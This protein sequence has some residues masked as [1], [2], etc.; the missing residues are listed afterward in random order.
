MGSIARLTAGRWKILLPALL[1]AAL[2]AVGYWQFDS[3][4]H[5]P[6]A[7]LSFTGDL[8]GTMTQLRDSDGHHSG[9]WVGDVERT[10]QWDGQFV[11]TVN[12]QRM[13]FNIALM[14]YHG[15]GAYVNDEIRDPTT[16][17]TMSFEEFSRLKS[18]IHLLLSSMPT[19]APDVRL[20]ATEPAPGHVATS[21][22]QL[23]EYPPLGQASLTL[24]PDQKSGRVQALLMNANAPASPTVRVDGRFR[25][26]TLHR[27]PA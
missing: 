8:T 24:D 22:H 20:Y 15:A 17:A 21:A 2:I 9:C 13:E 11:G 14:P 5:A 19:G 27:R 10:E 25:C 16:L 7:N 3:I 4:S 12:G 1:S 26:G 18:P 23:A 6:S